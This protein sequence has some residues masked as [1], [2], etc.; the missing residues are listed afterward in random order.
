MTYSCGCFTRT[1][2]AQQIIPVC[3]NRL[4]RQLFSFIVAWLSPGA[5]AELWPLHIFCF[6]MPLGRRFVP[7]N[8]S[9][10]IRPCGW[11]LTFTYAI[12]TTPNALTRL[13]SIWAPSVGR[14]FPSINRDA[15]PIITGNLQG[16]ETSAAEKLY[17]RRDL[18]RDNTGSGEE[19]TYH[20]RQRI[21][22]DLQSRTW[23]SSLLQLNKTFVDS[24][25]GLGSLKA[26]HSLR[27]VVLPYQ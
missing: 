21:P 16:V 18:P 15:S 9:R 7:S 11:P 19:I 26:A 17:K 6:P 14:L 25:G 5:G 4:I 10:V 13:F 2:P 27:Y 24:F 8:L 20:Y 12:L 1:D 3:F 23:R 22:L